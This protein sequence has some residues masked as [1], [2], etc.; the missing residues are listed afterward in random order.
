MDFKS[1]NN[2]GTK[3]SPAREDVMSAINKYSKL[4]NEQLMAE[5][6]KHMA[7]GRAKGN[8]AQMQQVIERIKPLLNAEQRK[9]LEE[10]LKNVGG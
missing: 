2:D 7:A 9:R 5:L 4:S 10:I 8:S 3:N 1:Y 6:A